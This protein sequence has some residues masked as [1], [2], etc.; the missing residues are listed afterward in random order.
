MSRLEIIFPQNFEGI[1][2]LPFNLQCCCGKL[3]AILTPRPHVFS[4]EVCQTFSLSQSS[5]IS[6]DVV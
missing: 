5:E 4:L 6:C 1:A 3:R 2:P